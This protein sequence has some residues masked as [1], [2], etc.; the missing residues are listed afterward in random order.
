MDTFKFKNYQFATIFKVMDYEMPFKAGRIK[1]KFLL[2][3][4]PHLQ[5][6]EKDRIELAEKFAERDEKGNPVI[7]DNRYKFSPENSVEFAKDFNEMVNEEI[8]VQIPHDIV[9]TSSSILENSPVK[10]DSKETLILDKE[11]LAIL[12]PEEVDVELVDEKDEKEGE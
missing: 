9:L 10:I 11:V 4:Q 5:S 3:L 12:K 6:Y 2:A 8:T 7:E 1:N